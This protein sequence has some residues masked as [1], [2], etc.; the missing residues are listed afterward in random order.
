MSAA[1]FASTQNQGGDLIEEHE[2]EAQEQDRSNRY[3]PVHEP[4]DTNWTAVVERYAFEFMQ[5]SKTPSP[6]VPY[7]TTIQVLFA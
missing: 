2:V 3:T 6:K 7:C 4:G 1:V 5:H